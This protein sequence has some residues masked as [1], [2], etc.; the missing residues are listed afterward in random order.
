MIEAHTPFSAEMPVNI[1]VVDKSV[2]TF[3]Q[4]SYEINEANEAKWVFA[5]IKMGW[6]QSFSNTKLPVRFI[7]ISII[8]GLN[9][10]LNES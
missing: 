6:N 1:K 9:F 4:Q 5:E 8:N 7:H 2:P 3:I 10:R